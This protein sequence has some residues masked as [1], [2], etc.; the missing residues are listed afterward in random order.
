MGGVN[1]TSSAVLIELESGKLLFQHRDD[2]FKIF[3][4]SFYG[5]FGGATEKNETPLHCIVRE[6]KEE[7]SIDI[8]S[9]RFSFL[10][11]MT[12]SSKFFSDYNIRSRHFYH[13]KITKIEE[14]K[15]ILKEGQG[16]LKSFPEDIPLNKIVPT[17]L[18]AL[19]LFITDK[20]GIRINP[21][22]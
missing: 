12:F 2:S 17:D 1:F 20:N 9:N 13:L 4:P 3:F 18:M 6:V 5:F 11:D 7:L 8:V 16:L 21:N 10:L 14:E 19:S 15:I 22:S